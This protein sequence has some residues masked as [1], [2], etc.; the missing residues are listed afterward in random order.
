M[1]NNSGNKVHRFRK[2]IKKFRIVYVEISVHY[3]YSLEENHVYIGSETDYF[4]SR[5]FLMQTTSIMNLLLAYL[6]LQSSDYI[7]ID[8]FLYTSVAPH[9]DH[10]IN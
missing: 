6:L 10:L 8:Q 2:P 5:I 4:S 7:P 3:D 9:S 1:I